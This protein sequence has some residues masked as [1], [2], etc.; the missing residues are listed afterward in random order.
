MGD[1][2]IYPWS[3]QNQ[4]ILEVLKM[5]KDSKKPLLILGTAIYSLIYLSSIEFKLIDYFKIQRKSLGQIMNMNFKRFYIRFCMSDEDKLNGKAKTD[6]TDS[7]P[8]L[9]KSR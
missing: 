1:R 7:K 4:K 8:S 9:P 6:I 2:K 3:P 5:C